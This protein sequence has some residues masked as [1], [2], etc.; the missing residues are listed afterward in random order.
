MADDC[1]FY[2]QGQSHLRKAG[3]ESL[4]KELTFEKTLSK[5]GSE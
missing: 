4:E 5:A 1:C 2:A 3:K